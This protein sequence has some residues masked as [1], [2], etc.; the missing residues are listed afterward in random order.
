[1]LNNRLFL[2]TSCQDLDSRLALKPNMDFHLHDIGSN[3][4]AGNL[5]ISISEISVKPNLA[6][7]SSSLLRH[8]YCYVIITVT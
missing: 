8:R 6:L 5:L 7:T 2:H 1:M 4:Y 3:D